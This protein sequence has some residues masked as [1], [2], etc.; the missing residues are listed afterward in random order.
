[1]AEEGMVHWRK[2]FKIDIPVLLLMT[3][4]FLV[5]FK[6]NH[7]LRES[8]PLRAVA[9]IGMIYFFGKFI[10]SGAY[11]IGALLTSRYRLAMSLLVY[12][13]IMV[14]LMFVSIRLIIAML[15]LV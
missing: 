1:M 12:A 13:C 10:W 9:M 3:L 14:V 11:M 6:F 8:G 7:E 4:L 5:V 2:H 15:D